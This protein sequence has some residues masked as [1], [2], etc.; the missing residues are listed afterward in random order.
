MSTAFF[1]SYLIGLRDGLEAALV[2]TIL[3]TVVSRS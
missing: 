1:A 3:L 2:V